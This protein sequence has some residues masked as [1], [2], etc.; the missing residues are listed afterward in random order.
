MEKGVGIVFGRK[1]S[2]QLGKYTLWIQLFGGFFKKL[3]GVIKVIVI[4][5]L[6]QCLCL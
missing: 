6:Y 3:D 5:F 4:L 2:I 1:K